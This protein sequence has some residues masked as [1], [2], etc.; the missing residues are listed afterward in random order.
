MINWYSI[1]YKV[2][3]L[4]KRYHIFNFPHYLKDI[5]DPFIFNFPDILKYIP[6]SFMFNFPHLL[7]DIPD[8]FTFNFPHFLKDIKSQIPSYLTSLTF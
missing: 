5:P 3:L 6:D 7:K 4:F 8:P 2:V 1:S